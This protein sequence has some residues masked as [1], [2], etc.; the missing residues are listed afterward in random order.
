MPPSAR[1]PWLEPEQL[2]AWRLQ[3]SL[4]QAQA[5]SLIGISH[6][7]YNYLE[8]GHTPVSKMIAMSCILIKELAKQFPQYSELSQ[9]LDELIK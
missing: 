1:Q 3:L 5:A 9:K 7:H 6:R 4:S 2:K 8:L